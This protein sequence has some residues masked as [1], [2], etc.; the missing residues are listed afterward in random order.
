VLGSVGSNHSSY[1]NV[2]P[3]FLQNGDFCE[4][5]REKERKTLPLVYGLVSTT[6]HG[7]T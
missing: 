2:I 1:R 6:R 4:D 7:T 3:P 5:L